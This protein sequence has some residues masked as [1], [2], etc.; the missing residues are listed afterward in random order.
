M[1]GRSAELAPITHR[2][3]ERDA[4]YGATQG[5]VGGEGVEISQAEGNTIGGTVAEA[6]NVI[7]ANGGDG[8]VIFGDDAAGN[9]VQGNFIGTGA[10]G[11]TALGNDDGV[12]ISSGSDST[13]GSAIGG[14]SEFSQNVSVFLTP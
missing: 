5:Y 2:E 10:N 9:K 6:R 12:V 4:G 8:V 13:I 14:T 7:S 11:T 3:S 1:Q